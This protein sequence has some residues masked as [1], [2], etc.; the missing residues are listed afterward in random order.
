MYDKLFVIINEHDEFYTGNGVEWST[1][2]RKAKVYVSLKQIEKILERPR[3]KAVG[4]YAY[5]V[6]MELVEPYKG[7]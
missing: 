4:A 5:I 6:K 7:E 2:L 1:Q 3:F